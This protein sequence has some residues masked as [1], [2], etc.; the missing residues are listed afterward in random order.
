MSLVWFLCL[1]ALG[2]F[3]PY[4]ALYLSENLAL[5]GTQVGMVLACLPLMG[6]VAQPLWGQ[7]ADRS[8]SRAGVLVV[9]ALGAGAGYA[10][11][12]LGSGFVSMLLLTAALACFS[13]PVIPNAF[14]VTLAIS[15]D[16]GPHAFGL[17][18]VWGTVGF[19]VAVLALPPLLGAVEHWRGLAATPDGPSEPALGIMFPLTGAVIAL[20]GL[21][22][23]GLPRAGALAVRAARGDWRRLLGYGPYVRVVIF[24]FLG[25]LTLHG[26][27]GLFPRYVTAHGGSIETVS[28]LWVPMLLVEIPLVALSG[29]S[30]ERVGARGLL[31]IGVLGGGFRWLFCGLFPD[32]P[33][34]LP[35][36]GLHG[37]VVA[38]LVIGLPL[39]VEQVVPESLRSTGQ[40]VLAMLG[41]SLGGITSY[42]FAGWLLEHHGP[43]AP[44]LVGGVAALVLGLL[45]PLLLPRPTRPPD[46]REKAPVPEPRPLRALD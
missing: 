13:T 3:F 6:L 27:M 9:L 1:G 4:F 32:S 5:P 46:P 39:Y 37:V 17:T 22:A 44:Y 35:I 33:W 16:H 15:R 38:G 45:L 20:G 10:A 2:L 12:S 7:I 24:G 40:G 42:L 23:L 29:A 14:A 31:A 41:N 26:P 36:Q 34:I 19:M 11:L 43:D 21:A 8:G 18:R 25:Y 28:Q 30:L